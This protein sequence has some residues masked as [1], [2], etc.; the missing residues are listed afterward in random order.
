MLPFCRR[1]KGPERSSPVSKS[2]QQRNGWER[3]GSRDFHDTHHASHRGEGGCLDPT[4]APSEPVPGQQ[5]PMQQR[6]SHVMGLKGSV[7]GGPLRLCSWLSL[8]QGCWAHVSGVFGG[9]TLFPTP[10]LPFPLPAHV[11]GEGHAPSGRRPES[12]SPCTRSR[13]LPGGLGKGREER[14]LVEESG[15]RVRDPRDAPNQELGNTEGPGSLG[16]LLGPRR[17]APS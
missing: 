5:D 14:L 13:S 7:T 10:R 9:L 3:W 17:W 6:D 1:N 11:T 12:R 16:L 8:P 15:L 2:T 4:E